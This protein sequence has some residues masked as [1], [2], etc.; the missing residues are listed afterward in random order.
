MLEPRALHGFAC[1]CAS[2]ARSAAS[3]LGLPG[4]RLGHHRAGLRRAA[5][6][7]SPA[8]RPCS[9]RPQPGHGRSHR[10]SEPVAR[11]VGRA[12]WPHLGGHRD[13]RCAARPGL[14]T[15]LAS[16]H[17]SRASGLHPLAH[18]VRRRLPG[19]LKA[20]RGLHAAP[21]AGS[22]AAKANVAGR[23]GHH[24]SG[25]AHLGRRNLPHVR[26]TGVP[27]LDDLVPPLLRARPP[28]LGCEREVGWACRSRVK[29]A[30]GGTPAAVGSACRSRAIRRAG[31]T[32]R[33]AVHQRAPEQ[34]AREQPAHYWPLPEHAAPEHVAPEQ[35]AP[36][37]HVSR[38]RS[39]RVEPWG[40][41]GRWRA[42]EQAHEPV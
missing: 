29:L 16:A 3:P 8:P 41:H 1:G 4:H 2:D 38:G 13:H 6:S 40:P 19:D 25:L 20:R 21:A 5:A 24:R 42:H 9:C 28:R 7:R 35:V 33:T 14:R 39:L 26:A 17:R 11:R 34:R 23:S 15:S 22:R 31:W 12:A 30:A 27:H 10:R 36:K 37:R 32:E 18:P